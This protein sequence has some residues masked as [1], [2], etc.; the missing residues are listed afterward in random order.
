MART[1]AYAES[2]KTDLLHL[3]ESG[4]SN[5]NAFEQIK[6]NYPICKRT[7]DTYW[8]EARDN[9]NNHIIVLRDEA[10]GRNRNEVIQKMKD[11]TVTKKRVIQELLMILEKGKDR[12][13]LNALKLICD[14][15]GY[16]API[17]QDLTL[18]AITPI[19]SH[20]PLIDNVIDITNIQ[21]DKG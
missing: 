15:E 18:H 1:K 19:F 13:K 12:D 11:N 9:Y 3:I 16:K 20:N 7:F 2:L 4:T 21:D 5:K 17:K 8:C 6:A 14:I 10:L